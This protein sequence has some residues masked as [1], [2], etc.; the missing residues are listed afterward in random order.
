MSR[1]SE[2]TDNI[3]RIITSLWDQA[4]NHAINTPNGSEYAAAKRV[5][6]AEAR[7]A[8]VRVIEEARIDE[9]NSSLHQFNTTMSTTYGRWQRDRIA[10]LKAAAGEGK[11]E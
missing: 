8:I 7:A 9:A 11:H 6:I 3:E 4:V 1:P 10:L 5:G 2:Q